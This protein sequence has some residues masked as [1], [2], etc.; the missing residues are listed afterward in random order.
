M[1]CETI[2]NLILVGLDLP[3]FFLPFYAVL[4]ALILFLKTPHMKIVLKYLAP[5]KS[6]NLCQLKMNIS[7]FSECDLSDLKL[8]KQLLEFPCSSLIAVLIY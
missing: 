8:D 1:I 4:S 3:F 6:E 7:L 2:S 5:G